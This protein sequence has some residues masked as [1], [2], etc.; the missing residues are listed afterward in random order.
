MK[1]DRLGTGLA[2]AG[3]VILVGVLINTRL[4]LGEVQDDLVVAEST[5]SEASV[6]AN[7]LFD[8]VE[9]LRGHPVV[10]PDKLDLSGLQGVAGEDGKD[11]RDGH[12]G[13]DGVT[14]ACWFEQSRCRG[15]DGVDGAQGPV[16]PV[17]PEGPA[18][19]PGGPQGPVGE[20]GATGV[21]GATGPQ[22]APGPAVGSFTF[23]WHNDT[24]VCSDGDHDG[25]Y[26]CVK[27]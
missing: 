3:V 11:G 27:T 16:G 14:P 10:D 17:G 22:G 18:G 24:Y 1:N 12:D 7:L 23:V 25:A 9:V 4:E 13:T 5:A 15:I 19:A 6:A 26:S 8:Q 21:A 20:T 2:V